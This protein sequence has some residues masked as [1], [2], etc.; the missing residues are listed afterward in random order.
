[1][2]VMFCLATPAAVRL[3]AFALAA[4]GP[5]AHAA[6]TFTP[7][8]LPALPAPLASEGLLLD[9][10]RVG[11]A[12]VAAGAHGV[13]I[14]SRD[15]GRT[16]TQARVPVS[17]PL[18]AVS[19]FDAQ[20]GWAVGHEGVALRTVDGGNTWERMAAGAGDGAS[21]LTVLALDRASVLVG[22]AYGTL[23]RS[24]DGGTT[25]EKLPPPAEDLHINRLVRGSAG[26]VLLAGESGTLA[27]SADAGESWEI[28]E[29]P[30]E[31]SFYGLVELSSGRLLAHGLRGHVF[32]SDDAGATWA[33]APVGEAVLVMG[34]AEVQPGVVVLGAI[35][36]HLFVS[37]DGGTA[38]AH[39]QPAGLGSVAAIVAA[40]DGALV[41]VGERGVRRETLP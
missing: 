6:Q 1:M 13:I 21:L 9:V 34:S 20:H 40:A 30:Y 23:L 32:T 7:A 4:F 11:D 22:G 18:T 17:V 26:K 5:A 19:F 38:F 25:W 39:H 36:G 3:A 29:S 27:V 41:A 16:W 14:Q 2:R 15:H 24:R 28:L 10:T 8:D 37:R 35:G 12:L 31:G 33:Q